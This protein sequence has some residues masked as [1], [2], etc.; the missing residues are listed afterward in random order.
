MARI[1]ILITKFNSI[2]LIFDA[3]A[4]S[5]PIEQWSIVSEDPSLN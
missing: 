5:L 4:I 1:G 2:L 3:I